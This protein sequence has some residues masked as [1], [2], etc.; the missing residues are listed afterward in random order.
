MA[1]LRQRFGKLVAAHRR[2]N[3]MT[4]AQLADSARLSPTMIARIESGQ[5]GARFPSI[6][7]LAEALKID[8]AELF[9][10]GSSSAGRS[11]PALIEINAR[12][13]GLSDRDL[14]WVDDL[15]EIALKSRG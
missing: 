3:G 7:R 5:T 13:T 12:L 4:Q 14:G 9:A 8:P 6:E 1:D 10:V 11:R 15:L 2:R